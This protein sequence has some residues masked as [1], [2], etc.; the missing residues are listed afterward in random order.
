MA[1]PIPLPYRPTGAGYSFFGYPDGHQNFFSIPKRRVLGSI[2]LFACIIASA[3]GLGQSTFHP[4]LWLQQKSEFSKDVKIDT[5][6]Y[7]NFNKAIDFKKE[8]VAKGYKNVIGNKSS[9]FLVYQSVDKSESDILSIKKGLYRPDVTS[10]QVK[11]TNDVS[12]KKSTAKNGVLVSYIF[13]KKALSK[14]RGD[15]SFNDLIYTDSDGKHKVMELIVLPDLC[16][17]RLQHQI[18]SYLSIKYGVSLAAAQDYYNSEYQKIWNSKENSAYN[19]RVTGI[20][21]DDYFG[22]YQKQSGNAKKDGLYI[23]L[24]T[25]AKIN[26]HNP[27]KFENGTAMLWADNNLSTIIK[28]KDGDIG[29]M[30]RVWKVKVTSKDSLAAINT[31]M[32]IDKNLKLAQGISKADTL[33]YWMAIDTT[34]LGTFNYFDAWYIKGK[35]K[36]GNIYFNGVKW[37]ASQSPRFTF[38]QAADL[39]MQIQVSENCSPDSKSKLEV[40][41]AG[42]I[43]PYIIRIHNQDF[44]KTYTVTEAKLSV[45]DLLSGTYTIEVSDKET[46]QESSFKIESYAD[47]VQNLQKIYYAD[48]QH[49]VKI[50]AAIIDPVKYSCQWHHDSS[51]VGSETTFIGNETGNYTLIVT[52]T[53]GCS[54]EFPFEIQP[55]S[56]QDND[57]IKIFP[58][59]VKAGE[60]VFIHLSTVT[61][62]AVVMSIADINGKIIK[63]EEI[64][65]AQTIERHH[66]FITAGTY[67]IS[68]SGKDNIQTTKIIVK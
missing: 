22:L 63:R 65:A 38:I 66:K 43:A 31:Q 40:K 16:E 52:S 44:D 26:A 3:K 35:S 34:G 6:L 58:N 61:A 15:L 46:T 56:S 32:I 68:I 5:A 29:K 18:E 14:K 17:Y 42:G 39:F 51:K 23:G 45:T 25:I 50:T 8:K 1:T 54:R 49:P 33:R 53:D 19:F 36:D 28:K 24:D 59:P 60:D 48:A 10:K 9:V 12:L 47:I 4:K 57:S 20:G 11:A 37:K 64:P 7:F 30:E 55:F 2:I 21:R 67:L 41:I 27:G 62:E 13:S